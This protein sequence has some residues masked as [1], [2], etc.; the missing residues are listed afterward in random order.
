M[1]CFLKVFC[2]KYVEVVYGEVKV[3]PFI[4]F[5]DFAAGCLF[6]FVYVFV[7]LCI[8]LCGLSWYLGANAKYNIILRVV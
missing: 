1:G 2:Y 5:L 4:W 7:C 3:L 6:V 8:H